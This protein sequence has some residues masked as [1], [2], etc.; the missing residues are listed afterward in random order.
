[1]KTREKKKENIEN[2]LYPSR[3]IKRFSIN[4]TP[5]RNIKFG[6]S[7]KDFATNEI[8][9]GDLNKKDLTSEAVLE[10]KEIQGGLLQ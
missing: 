3:E 1:L 2:N 6:D 9:L 5:S 10:L 4:I 7:N 8:T